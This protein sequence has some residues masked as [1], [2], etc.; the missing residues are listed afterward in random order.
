MKITITDDFINI[1]KNI[2][3]PN[4]SLKIIRNN[5][6]VLEY[7]IP[8]LFITNYTIEKE[9]LELISILGIE[10]SILTG[11]LIT[12]NKKN[13]DIYKEKSEIEIKDL[14]IKFREINIYTN[15][16]LIKSSFEYERKYNIELY[17][18][19][20]PTVKETKYI[21]VPSYNIN[22]K[23][24]DSPIK[25][26]HILTTNNYELS[27]TSKNKELKLAYSSI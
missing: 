4:T 27:P 7:T 23:I 26:E 8:I 12:I 2:N 11:L 13:N 3:E 18:N 19:I 14:I 21:L 6:K 20:I 9:L 22:D 24:I 1:V 25:Q 15:Y 16:N 17:K 5:K 10:V